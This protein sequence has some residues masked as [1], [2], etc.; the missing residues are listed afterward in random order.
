MHLRVQD[1]SRLC[2]QDTLVEMLGSL[3]N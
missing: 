1:V 2:L 3:Q